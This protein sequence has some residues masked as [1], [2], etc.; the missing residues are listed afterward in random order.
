MKKLTK[1]ENR[2]GAEFCNDFS[3]KKFQIADFWSNVSTNFTDHFKSRSERF[4]LA[5]LAISPR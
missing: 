3:P 2:G 4:T 5:L 1:M